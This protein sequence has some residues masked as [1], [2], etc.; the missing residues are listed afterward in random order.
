MFITRRVLPTLVLGAMLLSACTASSPKAS[1]DDSAP[2]V[3]KAKPDGT[4]PKP[5][6]MMTLNLDDLKAYEIKDGES[7][8]PTSFKLENGMTGWA[9]KMP[10]Q[11]PMATPAISNGRLFVGGGFGSYD[12]Y[13]VDVNTGDMIWQ[14][15]TTDDGPTG[16]V[17]SGDYVAYNTES[18]TLEVRLCSN[19]DLVWGRWL[20]DPLMSQP[21]IA[22]GRVLICWPTGGVGH[23]NVSPEL[24]ANPPEEDIAPDQDGD[25]VPQATEQARTTA[26]SSG[27]GPVKKGTVAHGGITVQGKGSHAIGCFDLK[28]GEVQWAQ[29]VPGD[30]ISAPVVEGDIVFAATLDGT[31]TQI[32]LKTGKLLGQEKQNATSAPW[33]AAEN[34][35]FE[36]ICS[37]RDTVTETVDGK[38]VRVH[39]EG[40]RR[41]DKQARAQGDVQQRQSATYLDRRVV[42]GNEYYHASTKAAQDSGVGFAEAPGAAKAGDAAQNVGEDSIVGLWAFQG[43]RPLVHQGKLYNCLGNTVSS[44]ETDGSKVDWEMT[45]RPDRKERLLSPPAAAG[46]QLIFAGLD[47]AVFSVDSTT[48]ELTHAM[49]LNKSFVFQPAVMDGKI[50]LSTQDGWLIAID[51]GDKAL[52][53]WSMWGGGPAH[54]GK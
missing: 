28:T 54:N 12:F 43:S 25:P 13:C 21:A 30:C 53:G 47:G 33:I 23:Q 51:T 9:V 49:K 22:D 20:G 40:W 46:G 2:D 52:S 27:P 11:L 38:E 10:Q 8:K 44:S 34:G 48:G 31:L 50:Y 42:A 45:Y 29:G 37:Q 4:K 35:K 7:G 5:A 39:Y 36:A 26:T 15:R 17:V 1:D 6:R 3:S 41:F 18:C 24:P 14:V 19:G 16:A 32:D